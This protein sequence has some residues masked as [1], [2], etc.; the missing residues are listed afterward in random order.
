MIA[1]GQQQ[2]QNLAQTL[3]NNPSATTLLNAEDLIKI[4][5]E[6]IS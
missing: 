5:E 6:G 1:S 3:Y 4:A 2:Q